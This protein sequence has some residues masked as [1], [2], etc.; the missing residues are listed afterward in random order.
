MARK[1][2]TVSAKGAL[3][4]AKE[5]YRKA[6]DHSDDPDQVFVWCFYA[7]ENAVVA[8]AT[9]LDEEFQKITG[10]RP[11]RHAGCLVIKV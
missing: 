8:S 4:L 9:H 2:K 1:K 7:L 10:R 6:S 5:Q 3:G 11:R